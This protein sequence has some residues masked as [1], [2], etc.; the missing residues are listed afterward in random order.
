MHAD[1]H[2]ALLAMPSSCFRMQVGDMQD[3][4]AATQYGHSRP[5]ISTVDSS[6]S[7]ESQFDGVAYSFGASILYTLKNFIERSQPTAYTAGMAAYLQT[8]AFGNAAPDD[9]WAALATSANLPNLPSD[10]ATYTDQTGYPVVTV[11]WVNGDGPTTGVGSLQLRQD[12]H[13]LSPYARSQAPANQLDYTWWIPLTLYGEHP[14]PTASPVQGAAAAATTQG[15]FTDAVWSTTIGGGAD[16]KTYN[17]ARDGYVKINGNW[18]GYYRVQYPMNIWNAFSTSIAAQLQANST[19]SPMSPADRAQ[20]LTDFY[21]FAY[22]QI[23]QS[24]GIN[25]AAWLNFGTWLQWETEYEPWTV[26]LPA[27]AQIRQLLV[28]DVPLTEAAPALRSQAAATQQNAQCLDDLSTYAQAMLG[29]IVA[30]LGF[31]GVS[32][33]L[34][35]L[36]RTSVL[37]AASIFNVTSV[38]T[39]ANAYYAGGVGNIPV[40]IQ[41]PVL[42]SAVRWAPTSQTYDEIFQLYLNEQDANV[43]RRYLGALAATRDRSLLTQLLSNS[44]NPSIIRSQ[45]T[46]SVIA[47]VAGNSFGRDL[48]WKFVKENWSTLNAR[49]GSGGFSLSQLVSSTASKFTTQAYMDDINAFYTAN[50]IPAAQL[51]WQQAMEAIGTNIGWEATDLA[52]TCTWLRNYASSR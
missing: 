29:P 30:N 32:T 2:R 50:P 12:R 22:G 39:T 40:N 49:Y 41:S 44:L 37:S 36:L 26:A 43:R 24:S 8:F 52:A 19:F 15:G 18:S 5:L 45:D 10:M 16:G 28:A 46:V 42:A 33:P 1:A 23:A 25:M 31:T 17:L 6:A 7:I 20:L 4:M 38:V 9:F 27:L 11:Q 34:T 14:D 51:D 48:A 3:A 13:F 35:D 47:S 21:T